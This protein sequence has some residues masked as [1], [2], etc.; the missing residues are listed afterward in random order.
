M[1]A[2]ADAG[3]EDIEP[4]GEIGEDFLRGG[5]GV[6]LD[7]GRVFELLGNPGAGVLGGEFGGA[8]DGA[9][10]AALAGGEV[11]GRAIGL[12][13]AAALDGHGFRH[14]QDELV[15]F[16]RRDQ[17]Q[18]DAGI[19]GSRLDDQPAGLKRAAGLGGLDHGE[20]DTVLDRPAGIAALG[21]DPDFGHPETGG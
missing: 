11:E 14:H 12:H 10:H 6:N 17:G 13:Q 16:D 19:A 21:F 2:G 7:I 1:A 8:L 20:R 18:A 4:F 15:A 5:A 9:F 3:D